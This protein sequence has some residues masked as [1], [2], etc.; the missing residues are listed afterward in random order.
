MKIQKKLFVMLVISIPNLAYSA[1]DCEALKDGMREGVIVKVADGDTASLKISSNNQ[2]VQVRFFGVDTP[3]SKWTGK[4]PAQ[5]YSSEA[6]RFTK[7]KLLGQ[8][9]TVNFNGGG[10]HHRCVG[11][12]FINGASHSLN[13]IGGGYGW[14]Y[15][16][17]SPQRLDFKHALE[18]ARIKRLGL[19][20]DSDP[21]APWDYR[22]NYRS[23]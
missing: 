14:W 10:T 13:I 15:K 21:V 9:V 11:E 5:A 8:E 20:A 22:R 2:I 1:V 7:S 16:R 12:I 4:W 19:W 3:E 18:S 17:F 6:K 23:Q